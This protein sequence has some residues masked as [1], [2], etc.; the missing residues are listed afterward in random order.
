MSG[1]CVSCYRRTR[2]VICE[3]GHIMCKRCALHWFPKSLRCPTCRAPMIR[4]NMQGAE[5]LLFPCVIYVDRSGTVTQSDSAISVG[6][7]ITSLNGFDVRGSQI[8]ESIQTAKLAAAA[9]GPG[10]GSGS[11]GSGSGQIALYV[12]VGSCGC[13]QSWRC[14]IGR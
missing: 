13:C 6:A 4:G 1:V 10:P 11:P 9:N 3:N 5:R 14:R 2:E 7:R 12:R 8:G